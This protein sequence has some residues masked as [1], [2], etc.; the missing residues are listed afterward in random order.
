MT[1]FCEEKAGRKYCTV[2]PVALLP[3]TVV[4]YPV[5]GRASV[6]PL[7]RNQVVSSGHCRKRARAFVA[8]SFLAIGILAG[9]THAFHSSL[10]RSGKANAMMSTIVA[11]ELDRDA[12]AHC[13]R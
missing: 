9:K 8:V 3:D 7:G 6:D 1:D 13:D 10:A 2:P 11:T 12:T 5:S 4:R